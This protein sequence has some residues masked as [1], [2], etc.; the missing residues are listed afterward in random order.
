MRSKV[1]IERVTRWVLAALLIVLPAGCTNGSRPTTAEEGARP[2]YVKG[3]PFYP[4]LRYQCGPAS[5]AAVLNYWGRAV[6]PDQIADAIYMPRLHGTLSLDLWQ[7]ARAQKLEADM[8]K[9]SIE[10][11][12]TFLQRNQPVI[13]LLNLG[14]QWLPVGHFLVVVGLDPATQTVITYSGREKDKHMSYR[15]FLDAWAKT[16]YWMLVV[17]PPQEPRTT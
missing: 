16:Q 10:A 3:V 15:E 14:Y 2:L 8:Q 13:A 5:L 7:Y 4:Q 9:G 12:A 6:S 11:L 17:K 1:R